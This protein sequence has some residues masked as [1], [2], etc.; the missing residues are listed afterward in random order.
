MKIRHY[1]LLI[2]FGALFL[3]F[4]KSDNKSV[5][6]QLKIASQKTIESKQK[7]FNTNKDGST[8]KKGFNKQ[9]F[10]S[11]TYVQFKKMLAR[12][13]WKISDL[14]NSK[15]YEQLGKT[16]ALYLA[17]GRIVVAKNQKII[18]KDKSGKPNPK[19]FYPAVFG[20]LAADEFLKKTGI[21]I[22]QT[23][24][25]RGMG[26]RNTV[27]NK[28]DAW[29]KKILAK[30]QSENWNSS[31]GFG[32]KVSNGGKKVY[33]YMHPLTIKKACLTCHGDPKGEKDV[34]GYVKEGYKLNEI[35]GGISV[36]LPMY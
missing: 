7:L 32:E 12:E 9:K 25:G 13:K 10:S 34:A 16:L 1:L 20:R 3:A 4:S 27:Y 22:K 14:E 2:A 11:Q 35:R 33:R 17:A 24:T 19:G 21:K 6:E 23:T 28:P 26:P 31:D 8:T 36:L 5:L 29:E 18:N 30:F 15:D